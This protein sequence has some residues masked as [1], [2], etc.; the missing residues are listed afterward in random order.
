MLEVL[1]STSV[2]VLIAGIGSTAPQLLQ[3]F[4]II[5]I[6]DGKNNVLNK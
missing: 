2:Q 4:D 5:E 3:K 1:E 6:F